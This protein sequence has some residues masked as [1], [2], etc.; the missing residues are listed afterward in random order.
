MGEKKTFLKIFLTMLITTL[1]LVAVFFLMYQ[2][3]VNHSFIDQK[4]EKLF[5][6]PNYFKGEIWFSV[7]ATCLAAVPGVLCGVLA[8]IQTNRIHKLEE[9]YHRPILS[10]LRADMNVEWIQ[11]KNYQSKSSDMVLD[12]YIKEIKDNSKLANY[13]ELQLNFE[14]KNEIEVKEITTE[15]VIFYINGVTYPFQ[16]IDSDICRDRFRY[17]SRQIVNGERRYFIKCVLY[18]YKLG[19]HFH[20]SEEDFWNG[21][22]NFTNYENRQDDEFIKIKTELIAKVQYEYAP[23]KGETIMGRIYWN[24]SSG[25]GRVGT[26][27]KRGTVDGYFTYDV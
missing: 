26:L 6:K 18:P 24:A 3:D 22:E 5:K 9:R 25:G 13:L 20:G 15:K 7:I 1:V 2:I 16:I 4:V 23:K 27:A 12:R 19:K 14:I 21:I 17:F 11:L 10:L 8:I